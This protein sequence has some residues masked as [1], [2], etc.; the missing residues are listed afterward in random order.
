MNELGKERSPLGEW[1]D[2]TFGHGGQA[3]LTKLCGID[4]NTATAAC[5]ASAR[6]LNQS[7]RGRIIQGLQKAGYKKYAEDFWA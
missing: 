4:K 7:T 1:V 6:K 5:S 3:V 2:K